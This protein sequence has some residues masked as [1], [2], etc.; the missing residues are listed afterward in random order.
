M[1]SKV[2]WRTTA[3]GRHL[4]GLAWCSLAGVCMASL[5]DLKIH[6]PDLVPVARTNIAYQCDATAAKIGL[7]SGRFEVEYIEGGG[8]SLVIVPIGGRSL[9]F[10]AVSSASGTRYVAQQYTW[11]EAKGSVTLYSDSLT[12]KFQTSCRTTNGR[13]LRR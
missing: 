11:W 9:I 1:E 2:F 6:L 4:K 13:M 12:G 3:F 7:P 5:T 8:N 10:S